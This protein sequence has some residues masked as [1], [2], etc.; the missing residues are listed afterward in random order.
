MSEAAELLFAEVEQEAPARETATDS[1]GWTYDVAT[2]EVLGLAHEP[3]AFEIDSVEAAEWSLKVRSEIEGDIAG[4]DARLR[5]LTEQL[6]AMR[7]AKVRQLS[8]WE[9]RFHSQ[10]VA[11]ARSQLA[12]KAKTWNCAW[13]KV[14]FRA[15]QGNTEITDMGAAVAWCDTWL[16]ETVQRKVWVTVTD[17]LKAVKAARAATGEDDRPAFLASSGPS[18]SVTVS[19]G[20]FAKEKAR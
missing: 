3:E 8:W 12:G 18:E 7:A 14:A 2:G 6:Q 19:T 13:G 17:A 1:E 5:A 15:T 10:L 11:F 20:V 4:I 9:W 16:P